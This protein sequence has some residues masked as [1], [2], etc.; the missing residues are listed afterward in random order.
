MF[1]AKAFLTS[2]LAAAA[3]AGAAPT[4]FAA[5]PQKLRLVWS[6][7]FDTPGKLDPQKWEFDTDSGNW[8]NGELQHYS[9]NSRNARVENGRLIIE[10]HRD[11]AGKYS[12]ARVHTKGPG[13]KYGRFEIR[14]K[15]PS[16]QG[17]WPALWMMATKQHYGQ[18]I[19]PDNGEIDIVEHVGREPNQLLA[20]FYTKNFIWMNNNGISQLIDFPE[21]ESDFHV[22][23]LDWNKDEAQISVDS[24]VYNVF[25]NP[26][27]TWQDWPF[28]QKMQLI[29][30]LAL[31]SY[32]GD[33]DDSVFPQQL[34][35]DY[36]RIYQ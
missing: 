25:K 4:T 6:D 2:V 14:A 11:L 13:F 31:G 28:D 7:E 33:M 3:F 20:N 22:Y 23:A 27:T 8:G 21:T 36:V 1:S 26:H 15:F 35:I 19:W 34:Q 9:K 10:A 30:N 5:R 29:M 17:T 18:D 32:G 12:S 24:I 16:G